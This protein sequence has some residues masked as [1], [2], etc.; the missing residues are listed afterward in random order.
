VEAARGC[1]CFSPTA[2]G[3]DLDAAAGVDLG[4]AGFFFEHGND[5]LRGAVAEELAEG[6]FVVLDAMLFDEGDEVLGR[7]A[8]E[9]G[10][11]EVRVCAEEVFGFR[12]DVGEVA[13]TTAGDEDFFAGAVGVVEEED[14]AAS[15]AGF[16]G[17]HQAGSACAEDHYVELHAHCVD[18]RAYVS[19]GD[20]D[21]GMW[22]FCC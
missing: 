10:L 8:G 3:G 14:A 19:R 12:A 7:E 5:L 13:A 9:R 21:A 2:D 11:G 6:F 15:F 16:D 4:L 22:P 18:C 17:C 1:G 20:P